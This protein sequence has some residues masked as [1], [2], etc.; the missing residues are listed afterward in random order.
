M[1]TQIMNLSTSTTETNNM[2]TI[3]ILDTTCKSSANVS[4]PTHDPLGQ[5]TKQTLVGPLKHYSGVST[6]S[7]A[8]K[9]P[10]DNKVSFLVFFIKS[11]I[12]DN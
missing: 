11:K 1:V 10:L 3:A 5:I 9:G 12:S 2:F 8:K 7:L 4:N 6:K